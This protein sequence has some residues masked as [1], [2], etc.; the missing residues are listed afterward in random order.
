M[1]GK[2]LS[3]EEEEKLLQLQLLQQEARK[4]EQELVNLEARKIELEMVVN[5]LDEISNQKSDEVLIP[6][7]NGVFVRGVIRD[8]E[9][10]LVNVGANVVMSK[11]V[12]EAKELVESQRR[13]ISTV[14][15]ELRKELVQYLNEINNIK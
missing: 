5:S 13:E 3:G 2:G 15:E 12:A 14:Q 8:K 11:S 1:S 4:L 9:N 6:I 7:G 10:V